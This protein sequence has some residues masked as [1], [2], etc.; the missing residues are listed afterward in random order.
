MKGTNLILIQMLSLV[1]PS[2]LRTSWAVLQRS[3]SKTMPIQTS[4]F[5]I[6]YLNL[7]LSNLLI[8]SIL[9]S[10]LFNSIEYIIVLNWPLLRK[11]DHPMILLRNNLQEAK[12]PSSKHKWRSTEKSKKCLILIHPR[13]TL[14]LVCLEIWVCLHYTN[15]Q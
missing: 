3:S 5:I 15:I 10:N 8:L 12:T 9:M 14:T 4:Q 7:S 13:F 6:F 2:C 11:R 1:I